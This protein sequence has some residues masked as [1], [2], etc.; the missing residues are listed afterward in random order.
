MK[1]KNTELL[2]KPIEENKYKNNNI[3]KISIN[4]KI[5]NIKL[6]VQQFKIL[7]KNKMKKFNK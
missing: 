2:Q 7:M 6:L 5:K 3:Y 4:E 1:T